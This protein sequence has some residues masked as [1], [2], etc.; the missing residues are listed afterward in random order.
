[1]LLSSRGVGIVRRTAAG[2]GDERVVFP[3]EREVLW[4]T[5][6]SRD[7]KWIIFGLQAVTTRPDIWALPLTGDRKAFPVVQT[8]ANEVGGQLSPD[9]RWLA[10]VATEAGD[11]QVYVQSFPK[12]DF[13]TRISSSGG[14][15]PRWRSDG[16]EIF[17]ISKESQLVAVPVDTTDKF[18]SG[19]AKVLFG[20]RHV[21]ATQPPTNGAEFIYSVSPD[22]QRFLANVLAD[23][24]S[25]QPI[26]VILNWHSLLKK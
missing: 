26:T 13:R 7:G 19:D 12:P 5:D 4:P 16:K 6:W 21:E 1:M 9:A 11:T 8:P 3:S 17:Y 15:M 24:Q 18:H 20:I 25:Q 10:Y 2:Q 23:T 22:G 14:G